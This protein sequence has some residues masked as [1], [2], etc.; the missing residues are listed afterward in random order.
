MQVRRFGFRFHRP[1]QL[2]GPGV[3]LKIEALPFHTNRFFRART[4][5]FSARGV[6]S[7]RHQ[8]KLHISQPPPRSFFGV[9]LDSHGCPSPIRKDKHYGLLRPRYPT[10]AVKNHPAGLH[11]Y[12]LLCSYFWISCCPL[13]LRLALQVDLHFAAACHASARFFV[14]AALRMNRVVAFS[15][16]SE[17]GNLHVLQQARVFILEIRGLR[18]LHGEDLLVPFHLGKGEPVRT[19]RHILRR[20][21]RRLLPLS[22]SGPLALEI[23]TG[24]QTRQQQCRRRR[25]ARILRRFASLHVFS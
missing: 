14:L 13:G 25:P 7:R 24:R 20:R 12:F 16:L 10:G 11:V 17:D 22:M 4:R 2:H 3:P 9:I 1:V 8:R 23:H 15:L 18:R 19:A 6:I 5:S 21:R